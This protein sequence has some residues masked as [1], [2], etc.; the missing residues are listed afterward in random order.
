MELLFSNNLCSAFL[1]EITR[2]FQ[3]H[4]PNHYLGRTAVQKLVYF[5]Q[6]IGVPIPCS[7]E[8]YNYGPY[9]D[10]V[11]FAVDS[12]VA[13]EVIEDKSND[14]SKYSNYRL[15]NDNFG[16][17]EPVKSKVDP[18]LHQIDRVVASLGSFRP[19]QLE[20]IATLHFIACR[21]KSLDGR[22][23]SRD[24]VVN[25]F[26]SIKGNK[27]LDS[28]IQSWFEALKKSNLI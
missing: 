24:I 18:Y 5:C 26:K 13:D 4:H 21:R 10:E 28:E 8:I 25:E 11:K 14:V 3:R 12:L 1:A 9:S 20:L 6:A 15:T 23:P 16:Y 2:S 22:D 17:P 7:F 27:F 19:G